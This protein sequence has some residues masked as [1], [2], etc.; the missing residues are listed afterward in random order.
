MVAWLKGKKTYLLAG[1]LILAVIVLVAMGKLTPQNAL[2]LSLLALGGFSVT[3]RSALANHQAQA[4]AI[5]QD[6]SQA[7]ALYRAG[8][9]P[10]SRDAVVRMV[11]DASRLAPPVT[12]VKG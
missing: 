4:L 1:L 5:L 12:G 10:A 11:N 8:N 7:G 3:F 6:A 9:I 2:A